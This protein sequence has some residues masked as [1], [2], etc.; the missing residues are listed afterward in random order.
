MIIHVGIFIR[1]LTGV[2]TRASSVRSL[3][4]SGCN[5]FLRFTLSGRYTY[6]TFTRLATGSSL[7]IATRFLPTTIA[8]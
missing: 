7:W 2:H 8:S 3:R 1:I 5:R 4:D 6:P